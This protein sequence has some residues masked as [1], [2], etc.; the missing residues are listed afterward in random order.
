MVGDI[1]DPMKKTEKHSTENKTKCY[2]TVIHDKV[3]F[4]YLYR[5]P[6]MTPLQPFGI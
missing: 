3:Y 6:V 2:F 5:V 4:S 1:Y